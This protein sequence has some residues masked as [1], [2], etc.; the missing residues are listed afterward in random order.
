MRGGVLGSLRNNVR[1][2]VFGLEDSLVST[3]GT[4]TGVAVGTHDPF[5]VVLTGVVLVFV[6]AI[7]MTAGSYL[8]SKSAK[9]LYDER[10]K[11]DHARVLHER[12]SDKESLA[13]MFQRKGF[14]KQEVVFAVEAIG[15]ERKMWLKEVARCEY[16]HA[17]S[18]S[19]TPVVAAMFMG[20]FY[21]LGGFFTFAPYLIL[22]I[23]L[24]IPV[25]IGL[26]LVAL[27][28]VGVFKAKLTGTNIW[29]SGV[30]MFAVSTAAAAM[31]YGLGIV[32]PMMFRATIAL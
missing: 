16:R 28:L 27:F 24:A 22:P 19:N 25:T 17:P 23:G 1:D 15:R 26:T 7:S 30:E 31:G 2:V 32:V 11:Q 4:V 8:S 14:S 12:V 13:E 6:E 29:R 3:L 21:L 10:A 20:V 9:E 18:V 5:Y